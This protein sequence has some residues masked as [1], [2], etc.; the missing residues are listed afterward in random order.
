MGLNLKPAPQCTLA[1]V[2]FQVFVT[3]S[4]LYF[5]FAREMFAARAASQHTGNAVTQSFIK[6]ATRGVRGRPHRSGPTFHTFHC[7]ALGAAASQGTII[8][9]MMATIGIIGQ[10]SPSP[11]LLHAVHREPT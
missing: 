4:V 10:G 1:R 7:E 5:K 2:G 3:V 8:M 6:L 11:L 9:M